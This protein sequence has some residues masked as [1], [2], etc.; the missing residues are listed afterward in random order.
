MHY[1]FTETLSVMLF[2]F[3]IRVYTE[4]KPDGICKRMK[5]LTEVT[6]TIG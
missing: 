3:T 1:N 6:L 2:F 5:Q 4:I